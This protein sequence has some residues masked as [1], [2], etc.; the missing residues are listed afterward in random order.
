MN[1]VDPKILDKIKKCLALA[2]SSE[3][4]EAAAAMRQAQSLMAKHNV[5]EQGLKLSEV[6]ELDIK[7]AVSVSRP[8]PWEIR[9]VKTCADA[10]GCDFL[11]TDGNSY[12]RDPYGRYTLIG[13]KSQAEVCQYTIEVLLRKVRRARAEFLK[14]LPHLSGKGKTV[15][16]EGFCVGWINA[17]AATVIAFARGDAETQLVLE[18]KAAKYTALGTKMPANQQIGRDGMEAGTL[19]A[20]G[21]SLYRPMNQG[22]DPLMIGA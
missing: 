10:F 11:W 17:I 9:L 5:S 22:Q 14:T 12:N 21:E 7:S 4:H 1:N 8:K 15:Q 19:A 2:T 3:P 20:K 6:T 18:Y 16:G 13:L